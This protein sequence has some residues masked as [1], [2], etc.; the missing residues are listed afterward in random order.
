MRPAS[1]ARAA[2]AIGIAEV[3][4]GDDPRHDGAIRELVIALVRQGVTS[5]VSQH[6]GHRYGVMH[7]DSNLPDVRLAIGRPEENHFVAS[8]LDEADRRAIE[9]SSTVSS[10]R[11]DERACGCPT[12]AQPGAGTSPSPTFAGRATCPS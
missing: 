2:R 1:E 6:D 4:V 3:V 5:T 11:P 7:I 9:P 12:T 10:R 8:V